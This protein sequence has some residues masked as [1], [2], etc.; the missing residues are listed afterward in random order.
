MAKFLG[1]EKEI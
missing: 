1:H